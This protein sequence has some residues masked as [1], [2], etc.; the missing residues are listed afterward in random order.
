M[1]QRPGRR[2]AAQ[3]RQPWASSRA[4]SHGP[5]SLG[6]ET[7]PLQCLLLALWPRRPKLP[8]SHLQPTGVQS[9]TSR[10]PKAA[11]SA[12]PTA[13]ASVSWHPTVFT[14]M[15]QRC[16]VRIQHGPTSSDRRDCRQAVALRVIAGRCRRHRISSPPKQVCQV[17]RPCRPRRLQVQLQLRLHRCVRDICQAPLYLL[18]PLMICIAL[19]ACQLR[20]LHNTLPMTTRLVSIA[21]SWLPQPTQ[22][23]AAQQAATS[24]IRQVVLAMSEAMA[25]SCDT[26]HAALVRSC[27]R[28]SL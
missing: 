11:A 26:V 13:T 16:I 22:R 27:H 10:L 8:S 3:Q 17:Q 18:P 4:P 1:T 25:A 24:Q 9:A 20:G 15:I 2:S 5:R 28:A 23:Q 6:A 19:P 7:S 12:T 21:C 14:C